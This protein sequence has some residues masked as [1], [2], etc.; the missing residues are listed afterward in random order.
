MALNCAGGV[1][2]YKVR[3][4]NIPAGVSEAAHL[5]TP[6]N[7]PGVWAIAGREISRIKKTERERL[8]MRGLVEL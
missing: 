6:S 8:V 3:K 1:V 4:E 7:V 2:E 5:L